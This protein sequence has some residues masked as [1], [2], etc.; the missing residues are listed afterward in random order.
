MQHEKLTVI[1]TSQNQAEARIIQGMLEASGISV[2]PL[3]DH[4]SG[5]VAGYGPAIPLRLA[6]PESQAQA[7]R[8]IISGRQAGFGNRKN[9]KG[10]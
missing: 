4:S 10:L 1:F 2:I 8:D 6:V 3:D 9:R 7:A 5:S